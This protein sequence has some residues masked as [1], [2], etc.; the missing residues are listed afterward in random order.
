MSS[1]R[2]ERPWRRRRARAA[3]TAAARTARSRPLAARRS[4]SGP[5][6]LSSIAQQVDPGP[7]RDRQRGRLARCPIRFTSSVAGPRCPQPAGNFGAQHAGCDARASGR[8]HDARC[9]TANAAAASACT[10]SPAASCASAHAIERGCRTAR[11]RRAAARYRGPARHRPR[12]RPHDRDPA[13]YR[14]RATAQ[15]HRVARRDRSASSWT[16]ASRCN[17]SAQR[18]CQNRHRSQR[19]RRVHGIVPLRVLIADGCIVSSRRLGIGQPAALVR[20]PARTIASSWRSMQV[21]ATASPTAARCRGRRPRRRSARV[22]AAIRDEH[23]RSRR[24]RAPL[25]STRERV[26]R[27]ARHPFARSDDVRLPAVDRADSSCPRSRAISPGAG[28]DR[29]RSPPSSRRLPRY[30]LRR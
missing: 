29:A 2:R 22:R 20:T 14:A 12:H 23:A 6:S 10:A 7:H 15:T 19:E 27:L 9:S 17:A 5:R 4:R 1:R 28:H 18:P 3:R 26:H 13:R 8:A 21:P 11:D 16:S 24:Q 30:P 25:P